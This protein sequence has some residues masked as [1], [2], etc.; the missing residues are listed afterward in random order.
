MKRPPSEARCPLTAAMAASSITADET[1]EYVAVRGLHEQAPTRGGRCHIGEH[2]L[3]CRGVVF[4]L[5]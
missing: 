5:R 1:L 4:E 3:R 2:E